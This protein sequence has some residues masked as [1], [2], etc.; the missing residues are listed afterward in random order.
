M[1]RPSNN[2][3]G[4]PAPQGGLFTHGKEVAL[5]TN[6]LNAEGGE[7]G[8]GIQYGGPRPFGGG[9]QDAAWPAGP[10]GEMSKIVSLEVK[11]EK[12]V[13]RVFVA[14]DKPFYGVIFSKV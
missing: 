7:I 2:R 9:S 11:C 8:P 3:P 4:R 5:A 6:D 10:D 1:N 12:N 14:F 13:M